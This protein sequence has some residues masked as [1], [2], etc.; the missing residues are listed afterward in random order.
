MKKFVK[1]YLSGVMVL[2]LSFCIAAC[3]STAGKKS[4]ASR[5]IFSPSRYMS[6]EISVPLF[7]MEKRIMS[8]KLQINKQLTRA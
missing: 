4:V 7:F 1:K 8:V 6:T 5:Y 3:G 2:F